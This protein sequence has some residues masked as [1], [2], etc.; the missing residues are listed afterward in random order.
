V[1]SE[2]H[3]EVGKRDNLLLLGRLPLDSVEAHD[4][5]RAM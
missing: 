2:A 4:D 5:I 3:V 1:V